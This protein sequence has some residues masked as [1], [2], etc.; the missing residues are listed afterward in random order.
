VLISNEFDVCLYAAHICGHSWPA[1]LTTHI[2]F[3]AVLSTGSV[4]AGW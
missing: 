4:D 2:G 1:L 3:M